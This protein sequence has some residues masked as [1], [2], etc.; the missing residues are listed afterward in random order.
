MDL[1]YL[2]S[3]KS[4]SS[5]ENPD[6]DFAYLK[7]NTKIAIIDDLPFPDFE[8]YLHAGYSVTQFNDLDSFDQLISYPIIICD[9]Q[10]VGKKFCSSAE[11]AYIVKEI[12]D[13]YPDK[14]VIVASSQASSLKVSEMISS[15]DK[16]I[17]RGDGDG[18]KAAVN[19]AVK[20]MGN[21]IE[22]WR[23]VRLYLIQEKKMD[24][25][26]VWKIEQEFIKAKA[27]KNPDAFK[28]FVNKHSSDIIKGLLVN[29]VSGLIF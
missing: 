24:L 18:L 25:F 27:N 7:R 28:S 14:Y 10:G 26:E 29:F 22:R 16:K 19:D 2:L 4:L 13:L 21:D 8:S 20:I 12:N 1:K 6:Q 3:K 17:N 5:I 11:G 9:L 23:R 15:A